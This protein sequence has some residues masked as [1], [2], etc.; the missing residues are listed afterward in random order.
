MS[1]PH[2]NNKCPGQK[3]TP[4]SGVVILYL[5]WTLSLILISLDLTSDDLIV[6]LKNFD[7]FEKRNY[8]WNIYWWRK[9]VKVIE[10]IYYCDFWWHTRNK[11]YRKS[12]IYPLGDTL[13]LYPN[14]K[15]NKT[16]YIIQF[17]WIKSFRYEYL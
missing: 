6:H 8:R 13:L 7:N 3:R 5:F 4:H 14:S 11:S 12:K 1:G 10:N 2:Y 9:Y 15:W 17:K 16:L